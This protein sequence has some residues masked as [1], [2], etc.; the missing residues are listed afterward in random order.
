MA[1]TS[2]KATT[3][4]ADKTVANVAVLAGT[5]EEEIVW[6]VLPNGIKKAGAAGEKDRLKISVFVAPRLRVANAAIQPHLASFADFVDWPALVKA[7]AFDVQFGSNPKVRADKVS[8]DPDST[9]WTALFKKTT[10]VE[11]FT[12][13]DYDQRPILDYPVI[14]VQEF[15]KTKYQSVGGDPINATTLPVMSEL[16]HEDALGKIA[17]APHETLVAAREIAGVVPSNK[18]FELKTQIL[19]EL[20][21]QK[22]F[23]RSASAHPEMDFARLVMM[24]EPFVN[25]QAAVAIPDLDFH[26]VL[27]SLAKYPKLMKM[28]GLVIDLEVDMA[29]VPANSTVKVFPDWSAIRSTAV[30]RCPRTAY[31]LSGGKFVTAPNPKDSDVEDGMLKLDSDKFE[32]ITLDVDGA[33]IKAM[34]L[35][36]KATGAINIPNSAKAKEKSG[37]PALRTG[38]I[39]LVRDGRAEKTHQAIAAAFVMYGS[40]GGGGDAVLYADDV[41]RGF[42]VDVWDAKSGKWNSLCRRKGT[43]RFVE[44]SKELTIDDEGFVSSAVT[45]APAGSGSKDAT[46]HMHQ[47]MFTWNGWSLCAARLGRT[48]IRK[49]VAG[50]VVDV[51]GDVENDPGVDFKLKTSFT[52]IKGSLPKLRFGNTYRLRARMVDLAGNSFEYDEPDPSDFSHATAPTLYGR[53]EPVGSPVLVQRVDPKG[54]AL[55]GVGKGPAPVSSA[56]SAHQVLAPNWGSPGESVERLVIRSFNKGPDVDK[57]VTTQT[58]DRHVA[59]PKVAQLTAETHGMFDVATGLDKAS[60]ST[61]AGHDASLEDV[62]PAANLDLPYLPDPLALGVT[63]AGLPGTTSA[64]IV[65]F[66]T[67]PKWPE[68]EPFRLKLA[69]GSG[70]PQFDAAARVLTVFLPKAEIVTFNLSS[71]FAEPLLSKIAVWDWFEQAASGVGPAMAPVSIPSGS[72]K[73]KARL[74]VGKGPATIQSSNQTAHTAASMA[75]Q[76]NGIQKVSISKAALG[77]LRLIA[78]EGRH[79]MITPYRPITL[80]HAVQQPLKQP[81]LQVASRRSIGDTGAYLDGKIG[82]H[83]KSTSKV[84]VVA[85]WNEPVDPISE[86]KWKMIPGHG[87]VFEQATQPDQPDVAYK[88]QRHEFHDTRYRKVRYHS[89]ATTRFREYF[90]PNITSDPANISRSGAEVEIDILSTARPAAPKVLYVIPTFGWQEPV[91]DGSS[92]IHDRKGGGLRVYLDRPWFS[93][94]EGELLGVVLVP[95]GGTGNQQPAPPNEAFKPYVTMWGID[96]IWDARDLQTSVPLAEQFTKAVNVGKNL[97]ICE[98]PA[99]EVLPG[100]KVAVAGHKVEYDEGRQ[101]WY[102]DIEIDPRGAYYPFIRLALARYQPKSV[103]NAHLSRVVLAE[104]AQLAPDRT[105]VMARTSPTAL[106]V[107]IRGAGVYAGTWLGKQTSEVEASVE[108]RLP[109]G[110]DELAW[111]PVPNSTVA[112]QPQAYTALMTAWIGDVTLPNATPGKYRLV[113]KEYER[114]AVD[115]PADADENVRLTNINAQPATDRRLVYADTLDI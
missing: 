58:T 69:E 57:V 30:S 115:K 81:Q 87:Q 103:E 64:K 94:G 7:F 100:T 54:G 109:G 3:K 14:H 99:T 28:M 92:T 72:A 106:K 18:A 104:F 84:E 40:A 63:L 108:E 97:S 15:I 23:A 88:D 45:K 71:H 112:L 101:L 89:V 38:G 11:S 53:F 66:Y 59:P 96:P 5:P 50:H 70:Q 9:L 95:Q 10:K 22:A 49:E 27:S 33:A 32:V 48:I 102:C 46:L 31:V 68:A 75:I 47:S 55:A 17:F 26:T 29:G 105:L 25:A 36:N 12:L 35:A 107:S 86:K 85:E 24:H 62:E 74:P 80:V 44:T 111:R 77:D 65:D 51:A 61:I 4:A 6:T 67:Q 41:T 93:S 39:S 34:E 2:R 19:A 110:S 13:E 78:G 83:P 76:G 91:K 20:S 56:G 60:Y 52:A 90:P 21:T 113:V 37:L 42:R 43:Y 16:A 114:Y 98:V 1:V 79:W 82:I 8:D 73:P